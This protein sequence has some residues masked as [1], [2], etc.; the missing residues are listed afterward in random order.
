M[1]LWF[2]IESRTLA[3]QIELGYPNRQ[4]EPRELIQRALQRVAIKALRVQMPLY[5][6]AANRYAL[7]KQ[8][9]NVTDAIIYQ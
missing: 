2:R 4:P 6:D 5:A 7:I 3:G 8:T 9:L 1:F